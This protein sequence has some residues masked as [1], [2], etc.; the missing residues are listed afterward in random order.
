MRQ[1]R[2]TPTHQNLAVGWLHQGPGEKDYLLALETW[3]AV[4]T[5]N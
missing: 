3:I 2:V 5:S 4:K 1:T